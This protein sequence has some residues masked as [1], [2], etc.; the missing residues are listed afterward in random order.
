[1]S[2][3]ETRIGETFDAFTQHSFIKWV[4]KEVHDTTLGR[5]G[6]LAVERIV[7]QLDNTGNTLMSFLIYGLVRVIAE[8]D[9]VNAGNIHMTAI[10]IVFGYQM[11][12]LIIKLAIIGDT[13][14]RYGSPDNFIFYHDSNAAQKYLNVIQASQPAV[15]SRTT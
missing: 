2:G 1:M 6:L 8:D 9:T 10:L 7:F 13:T 12:F 14:S 4:D 5:L 11:V 15:T 3:V